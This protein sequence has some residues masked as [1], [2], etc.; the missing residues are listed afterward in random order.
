[1]AIKDKGGAI[2][3][4]TMNLWTYETVNNHY[5]IY[6]TLYEFNELTT[7]LLPLIT[8]LVLLLP[9]TA[10]NTRHDSKLDI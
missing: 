10:L 8:K 9:P 5:T 4:C 3:R 6:Y 2:F 1:M 7:Y